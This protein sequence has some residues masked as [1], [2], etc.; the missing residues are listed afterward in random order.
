[1]HKKREHEKR[2]RER[3]RVVE[4]YVASISNAQRKQ[5]ACRA[6]A[7][8]VSHNSRYKR[9]ADDERSRRKHTTRLFLITGHL[10]WDEEPR[11]SF[12]RES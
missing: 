1:M 6:Y 12:S 11:F 4:D 10:D 2:K 8:N 3:E 9:N 7:W 5:R